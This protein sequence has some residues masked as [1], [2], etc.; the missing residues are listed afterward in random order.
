MAAP[1]R[2]NIA[3]GD[4]VKVYIRTN[5]YKREDATCTAINNAAGICDARTVIGNRLFRNLPWFNA[6]NEGESYWTELPPG[7]VPG[8]EGH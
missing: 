5:G 4:G 8:S 2:P 1:V 6:A 7:Y 3:V